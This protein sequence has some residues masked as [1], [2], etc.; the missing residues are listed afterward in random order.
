[1][2]IFYL[3]SRIIEKGLYAVD[4]MLQKLDVYYLTEE[5]SEQEYE[6][7]FNLVFPPIQD[8]IEEDIPVIDDEVEEIPP[9]IEENQ[10]SIETLE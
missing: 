4:D 1:M 9:T 10:D 2:Q 5:I 6:Y 7:L 3:L 8:E